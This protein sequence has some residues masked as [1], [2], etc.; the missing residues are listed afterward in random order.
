MSRRKALAKRKP[1]GRVASP[2]EPVLP[3]PTETYRL[4]E[5]ALSGMR[6]PI[7]AS[8]L[9]RLYNTGKISGMEFAAGK[10]WSELAADYSAQSLSPRP[11]R[12]A[13]LENGGGSAVDP[14]SAAGRREALRDVKLA[15]GYV[16]ALVVLQR[17]GNASRQ[18]VINTCE[19]G[20]YPA[21]QDGLFS[22]R[23]GLRGLGA[24]W[25]STRK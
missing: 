2:S 20:L 19:L 4:R 6:E 8:S 25:H 13:K 12:S 11:P 18:A 10:R 17:A 14:D 21:G 22:L 15:A 23:D 7:W 24:F 16:E 9:G 3:S 1:S 5:A